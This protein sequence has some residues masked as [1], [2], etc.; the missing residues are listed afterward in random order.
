MPKIKALGYIGCNVSSLS[1]WDE[2]MANLFSLGRHGD[3]TGKVL[4]FNLEDHRRLTLREAD[5]DSLSYVGWEV[6]TQDDLREIARQLTAAEIAFVHG[7]HGLREERAVTDLLVLSGPDRVR[8]ELFFGPLNDHGPSDSRN[9]V[10]GRYASDLRLAHIV[11]ASGNRGASVEWYRDVFG[12]SVSDHVFWDGVE[13]SFLRCDPHHHSLALT[14]PVG[15][16]HG[17]DLGHF[18][19]ESD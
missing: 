19:F 5:H 10:S 14:N 1:A 6:A 3:S 13:A 15:D 8:T 11:L 18:M 17:G 4:H 16:M 2:F 9:E 7:D 12:F